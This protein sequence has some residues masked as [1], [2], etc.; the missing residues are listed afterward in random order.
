MKPIIR[1]VILAALVALPLTGCASS[2]E[3]LRLYGARD[4]NGM[5]SNNGTRCETNCGSITV[6]ENGTVTVIEPSKGR[7][8]VVKTR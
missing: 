7:K 6:Y 8:T 5:I 1:P 3:V 2:F 4:G